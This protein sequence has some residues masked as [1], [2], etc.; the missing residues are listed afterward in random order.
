[1]PVVG[2]IFKLKGIAARLQFRQLALGSRYALQAQFFK[3]TELEKEGHV[4]ELG[5]IIGLVV[6]IL[7]FF[8]IVKIVGCPSY[9][10]KKTIR[11]VGF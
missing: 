6:L 1:M 9:I 10:S 8:A 2:A 5:G 4:M 11:P 3:E 7:D